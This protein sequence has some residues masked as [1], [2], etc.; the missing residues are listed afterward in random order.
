ELWPGTGTDLL[1][2]GGGINTYR[3]PQG[4][5]DAEIDDA[6][7]EAIIDFG[8]TS[9]LEGSASFFEATVINPG[10]S[11]LSYD[12]EQ[13]KQ[14]L[15]GEGGDTFTIN[16]YAKDGFEFDAR[17]GC[18]TINVPL[19]GV[20]RSISVT[21]SDPNPDCETTLNITGTAA[22]D[23]FLL[24]A[25]G[26]SLPEDQEDPIA[27]AE[28]GFVALITPTDAVD[29]VNYDDSISLLK[30]NGNGGANHFAIDDVATELELNGGDGGNTFQVGQIFGL[31][32]PPEDFI[33]G[34]E[35]MVRTR[36]VEERGPMSVGVSHPATIRGGN[37]DD[38]F[39]VYSNVA[40]LKLEGI[41]GD[42]VFVLRAFIL[43]DSVE[44]AGGDG[45]DR[46]EYVPNENVNIDGGDG[47]NTLIVIGTEL[48]DGFLVEEDGV[49]ICRQYGSFDESA[50]L[51]S[52]SP[53][54][55]LPNPDDPNCGIDADFT[56]IQSLILHGL[57]GNNA[58]W[59]RSTSPE[60]FLRL[61]GGTDGATFLIGDH[62]EDTGVHGD[63]SGI[64]GPVEVDGEA[65]PEFDAA[66]VEPVVLPGEDAGEIGP[67]LQVDYDNQDNRLVVD[68]RA[69]TEAAS[70]TITDDHIAGFNMGGDVT[71]PVGGG[72]ER[73]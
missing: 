14:V 3:I 12:L 44:A 6:A 72:E 63:L 2:G 52:W 42:N 5:G 23:T 20:E 25:D 19:S 48:S 70:G 64:K 30:V 33:A 56:N 71:I 13:V 21:D 38:R 69:E 67:G 8:T 37:G 4:W 58:F 46:F 9:S 11:K 65:D 50:P 59:V 47:F 61:F 22:G 73:E 28:T 49:K 27:A 31:D 24:R 34:P 55:R 36:G 57:H 29:R 43:E 26:P 51:P 16:R 7:G 17:G 10:H 15:A 40:A 53:V 54:D 41:S 68:G 18:D 32:N 45:N 1:E 60:Y 66:I 62:N 35:D 39:T